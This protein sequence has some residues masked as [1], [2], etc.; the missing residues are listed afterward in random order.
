MSYPPEGRPPYPGQQ[1]PQG[2][3]AGQYGPGAAPP[4]GYYQQPPKKKPV[5]PWILG[6]VAVV[7]LV[8]VGGCVALV[9][10]VVNEVD[11]ELNRQVAVTYEVEGSGTDASITYS[12]SDFDIAQETAATMPWRKQVTV[13]GFSSYVS[14]SATNGAN[15]GEI[16]CRIKAG[17]RVVS[18][19]TSSGP[20]ASASCSG[21]AGD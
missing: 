3:P 20:Y 11:D 2:Y 12:G 21:D 4:Q 1:Q 6:G 17:D 19:Q 9:A 7:L 8:V 13:E 16:T 10:G 18:E 15:G 5:W 14:L